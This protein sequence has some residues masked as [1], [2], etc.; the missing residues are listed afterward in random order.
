MKESMGHNCFTSNCPAPSL[1]L[2][3]VRQKMIGWCIEKHSH[4]ELVVIW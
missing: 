1:V 2:L 4:K 3:N